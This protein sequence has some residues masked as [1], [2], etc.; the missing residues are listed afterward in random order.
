MAT[1]ER[2]LAARLTQIRSERGMSQETVAARAGI[3]TGYLSSLERCKQIPRISILNG[4][5]RAL[6][7][8][9]RDLIDLPEDSGGQADSLRQELAMIQTRLRKC[10]LQ[11]V[12]RIRRSIEALI[13]G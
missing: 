6:G 13:G 8:D 3:S 1:F 10:D 5:A 11:T 9:L 12:R 7:V 4:I 2:R